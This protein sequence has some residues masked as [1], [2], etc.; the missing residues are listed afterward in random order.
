MVPSPADA[1]AFQ[2]VITQLAAV[3]VAAVARRTVEDYPDV[4]DPYLA[5]SGV[6]SAQWYHELAPNAAFAVQPAPPVS[7]DALYA[8]ARWAT[9]QSD[10]VQALG[11]STERRVFNTS[12]DTVALN[13]QREGV[14]YARH[15]SANACPWCRVLA[16]RGAVY[17]SE[18]TGAASHDGCHCIAVPVREGDT[19]ESPDYV[20]AWEADYDKAR[21]AVGGNLDDIANYMR[22]HS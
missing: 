16:T 5:A 15:A 3:A 18:K 20:A 8:S 10:P 22:S 6:L 19:Y 4:V 14:R 9:T 21:E 11:L 1:A 12:R 2:G 7:K 17:R 13:A